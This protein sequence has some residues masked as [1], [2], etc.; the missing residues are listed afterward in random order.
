MSAETIL[1]VDDEEMVLTSLSAYLSLETEYHVE[2][3]TSAIRNSTG[4]L[5]T[6]VDV[7]GTWE[8]PALTGR[9]AITDGAFD[10]PGAG[11]RL[12]RVEARLG[13][14]GDSVHIERLVAA[15][16]RE[17]GERGDTASLGGYV[18]FENLE[19]PENREHPENPHLSI[20]R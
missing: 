9:L 11:I 5:I 7:A 6:N 14:V 20:F 16:R 19:N 4:Q 13:L 2:T 15:S 8:R 1:L 12:E 18:K 17:D 3:F 10:L